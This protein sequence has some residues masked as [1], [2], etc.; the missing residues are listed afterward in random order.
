MDGGRAAPPLLAC[1]APMEAGRGSALA[2]SGLRVLD[3]SGPIGAYGTRLLADLGAD[4]VLV[5]PP[6]GDA[7]RRQPP[8]RTDATGATRSLLFETYHLNERS[9]TL[10]VTRGDA[11]PLLAELAATA[12]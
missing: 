1:S 10:D 2:L 5:E 12:D 11:V 7:M 3:L 4:V 8:L 6:G 9:T